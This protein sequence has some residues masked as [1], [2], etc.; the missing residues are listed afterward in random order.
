MP[1]DRRHAGFT[2]VELSLVLLI[3]GLLLAGVLD[4]LGAYVRGRQLAEAEA[5]L[6]DIE[7]ALIGYALRNRHLPCPD[8]DAPGG[9]GHGLEDRDGGGDCAAR[10]GFLPFRDLDLD[11]ARDPWGRP[12]AYGVDADFADPAAPFGLDTPADEL[13]VVS[14]GGHP[15]GGCSAPCEEWAAAVA[16]FYSFGPNGYQGDAADYSVHERE[17][18]WAGGVVGAGPGAPTGP[19]SDP[20]DEV[21]VRR[22]PADGGPDRFDDLLHW[23]G[24]ARLVARMVEAGRLP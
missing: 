13:L 18:I 2:L 7:T 22:A 5:A 24:P 17:N 21:Y 4:G 16:V 20:D 1:T 8:I 12:Y 15:P 9:P 11:A 14:A 19:A 6:R 10:V 23:I 3:V